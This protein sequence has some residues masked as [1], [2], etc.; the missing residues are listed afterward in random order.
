MDSFICIDHFIDI[1]ILTNKTIKIIIAIPPFNN[2][3]Y[4]SLFQ[5]YLGIFSKCP[6]GKMAYKVDRV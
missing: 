1:N 4:C 6:L 5:S 3:Y 2:T